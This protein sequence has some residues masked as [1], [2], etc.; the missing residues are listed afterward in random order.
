M[1]VEKTIYFLKNLQ[2]DFEDIFMY[3]ILSGRHNI[4]FVITSAY[5]SEGMAGVWI[6]KTQNIVDVITTVQKY[7]DYWFGGES[8][9]HAGR[10]IDIEVGVEI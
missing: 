1:P 7:D 4:T 8:E 2:E 3:D 6:L 9:G 5:P 10:V